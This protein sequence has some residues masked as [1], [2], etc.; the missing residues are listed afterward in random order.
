MSYI[1]RIASLMGNRESGV[2]ALFSD[3]TIITWIQPLRTILARNDWEDSYRED[4]SVSLAER[5]VSH[6]CKYADEIPLSEFE[7]SVQGYL[8]DCLQCLLWHMAHD[9]DDRAGNESDEYWEW[10][11]L[12]DSFEHSSLTGADTVEQDIAAFTGLLEDNQE[13]AIGKEKF[14]LQSFEDE[15]YGCAYA[16]CKIVPDA[17][18]DEETGE[19]FPVERVVPVFQASSPGI[20]YA[21]C[22]AYREKTTSRDSGRRDGR[23]YGKAVN[24]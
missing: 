10:D 20:L 13:F 8:S 11:D 9:P 1:D 23:L 7:G 15:E 16:L 5:F 22:L 19:T 17:F 3:G 24:D 4:P 18:T 2:V 6:Y 21:K 12:Q 14:C